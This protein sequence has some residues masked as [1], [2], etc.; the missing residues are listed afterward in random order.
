MAICLPLNESMQLY[1]KILSRLPEDI[2]YV[3]N[4]FL[5]EK[6]LIDNLQ[7]VNLKFMLTKYPINLTPLTSNRLAYYGEKMGIIKFKKILETCSIEQL[8][9]LY[10]YGCIEPL[11]KWEDNEYSEFNDKIKDL[12]GKGL[13]NLV[14]KL[15]D[16]WNEE[17]FN[18]MPVYYRN[19]QEFYENPL[20]VH[21]ES[22]IWALKIEELF[23]TSSCDA[24]WANWDKHGDYKYH[25]DDDDD[26]HCYDDGEDLMPEKEE[27]IEKIECVINDVFGC[28]RKYNSMTELNEYLENMLYNIMAITLV[29][30]KQHKI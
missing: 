26:W 2:A 21:K 23:P 5:F 8:D 30:Q 3:V 16:N 27:Y 10:R 12:M 9:K 4:E 29:F 24:L 22:F 7:N 13:E 1:N 14:N 11:Y 25:Y 15:N 20:H 19:S 17:N 18:K 28:V 6:C